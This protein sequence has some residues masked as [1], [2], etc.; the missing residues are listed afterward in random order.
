[1]SD[2]LKA[3]LILSASLIVSAVLVGGFYQI[4][5]VP[6]KDMGLQG[7][8]LNRFTG[9]VQV[10]RDGAFRFHV[11]TLAEVTQKRTASPTASANGDTFFTPEPSAMPR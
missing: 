4:S 9:D 8:R 11:R 10:I 3:A 6:D 2:T 7:Y 1:M 5:A